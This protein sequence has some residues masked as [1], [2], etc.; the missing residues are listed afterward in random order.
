MN[1]TD[2]HR[3]SA[4]EFDPQA[5]EL[6]DV[7]DLA[8][9]AANGYA[10]E[11]SRDLSNAHDQLK[12]DGFTAG[13]HTYGCGHCGQTN[14]RYVALLVREDVKEWIYA[15]QDCLAGRF[16]SQT[17]ESFAALK[18]AA[19]LARAKQAK[20]A[21]W[22]ALCD[23]NPALVW[24]SYAANIESTVQ[25]SF[26]DL[27]GQKVVGRDQQYLGT[28]TE[29]HFLS[30]GLSWGFNTVRDIARKARTYGDASEKQVA[31]VERI[32][33][34]IDGKVEA[35]RGKIAARAAAPQAGPVPTGRVV[36]EGEIVGI[37]EV[38]D[39]FSYHGGTIT[40]MTV[41]L[42]NGARVYGT[43][44]AAINGFRGDRVRFTATVEAS[45]DDASFGF[46][47]RPAKAEVLVAAN[48]RVAA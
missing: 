31:L 34:E 6:V 15:G 35:Y 24:A 39:N 18:K 14:L 38:E 7:Y 13:S 20:K 29:D 27:A 23:E 44:P 12:A 9:T 21:A 43:M 3:P 11:A 42:D 28:G 30:S 22:L 5:Y 10:A 41:K 2:I 32:L 45:N 19:E 48:E 36:I 16:L 8:A 1:R 17:K 26:A 4:P 40:K 33:G 25:R 37:K 46:A 47:K